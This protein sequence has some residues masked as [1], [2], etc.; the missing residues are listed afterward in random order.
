MHCLLLIADEGSCSEVCDNLYIEGCSVSSTRSTALLSMKACAL[1]AAVHITVSPCQCS[2]V[3]CMPVC[4][5]PCCI[6]IQGCSP[7]LSSHA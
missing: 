3:T 2:V 5:R 6:C 7:S 1:T 4:L